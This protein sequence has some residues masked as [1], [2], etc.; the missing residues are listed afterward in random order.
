MNIPQDLKD[1][2]QWLVW[3]FV[4]K[5][6][7]KKP[8]KIPYYASTG[9]LRSGQQGGDAD[10]ARL[11]DFETAM[12][13]LA[14]REYDGLGFAFLP[15]DGLIGIDLDGCFNTED[16]VRESR[17]RKIIDSCASFTELSPS[18]NGA[19][20]IVRG[21]TETFKSNELGIEVFCGSQ[22]FTV[23]GQH[24]SGTPTEIREISADVL[25]KLR[26]T[27]KGPDD[28]RLAAPV[29]APAPALSAS[30]KVESALAMISPDCGYE[31][32]IRIGMAIHAELGEGAMH[33][34][35]HWSS[36]GA[37]YQGGRDIESHWRSFKPGAVT[38]ATL[39]KIAM[40]NGWRPPAP[41]KTAPQPK[42]A[43]VVGN[44]DP[45]T[46]EILPPPENDNDPRIDWS[47]P[48]DIFGI[49][50]PPDLD[51][52]LLPEPFRAY[53]ADQA[54]L[55]GCDPAIIGLGAVVAAAAC[56]T[57]QIKL[58]PKAKDITWHEHPRLWVAFVGDP[59]TKKSPGIS[60]AVR[61]V[62]RLNQRMAEENAAAIA[63]WK[64]QH[65]S[66]KEAKKADKTNPPPEPQMPAERRLLVEDIT[67]EKLSDVLKDNPRGVLT[68]K[69]EL[70]G[71]F[72]SMDAYKGGGKGASMDRAHW[73]EAYN[74]GSH[75]IDR[76]TRGSVLIPNWSTCIVGGIQPD[77]MRAISKSMGNDGLLQ[78]FMIVV[79]RPA[80]EDE[81]R[82]PDM[83]AMRE[84]SEMF[85][86]LA[87]LGGAQDPALLTHGAQEC[88]RR[89][90]SLARRLAMSVDNPHMKAWLGKWDGLFGRLAITYH[91]IQCAADGVHPTTRRVSDA[92]GAQVE[93]LMCGY[94]LHH[95]IHFYSEIL[96]AH[97]RQEHLRQLGRLILARKFERLTKR[98]IMLYWKAAGKLDWWQVRA[99]VDTLC[100]MA[101]LDPDLTAI[102]TDGKPRA[103]FVNPAVHQMFNDHAEQE[104]ERRRA[105]S[106]AMREVFA[107]YN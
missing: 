18:G 70:T 38:G 53:T 82:S 83:D 16:A 63:D 84:F 25:A 34:W 17:A 13:A 73:L 7:A 94:L 55:T 100:T 62:K 85:D 79:A 20:I 76:V 88:R 3:R 30:A 66:W 22:F 49:R 33:V 92:I 41:P 59:S 46:G 99:V 10:R 102:D 37:S 74:G 23:T 56:I 12:E 80:I 50:P 78:R 98:D 11:V 67:V 39:F 61:H 26:R 6:G 14:L 106:E 58:Q 31:D 81:D 93:R 43:P 95:A 103:W 29:R 4:Q 104:R 19:H 105:A 2:P 60:K 68:L 9:E 57:D 1:I 71:W 64:W 52:D 97:D 51:L 48:M 96:D 5:P 107:A 35:D 77:M 21:Q 32:W 15:G 65:D 91:T 72:A 75:M 40:D 44:V 87:G 101:W 36:R 47:R 27:V 24:V 86:H 54:A 8:S 69:D 28:A 45:D 89:V 42:P 90:S